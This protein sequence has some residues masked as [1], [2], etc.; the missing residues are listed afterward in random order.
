MSTQFLHIILTTHHTGNYHFVQR[1]PLVLKAVEKISADILQKD[2][3]PG[4]KKWLAVAQSVNIEIGIAANVDKPVLPLIHIG[5][6]IGRLNSPTLR[7]EQLNVVEIGKGVTK[8]RHAVYS[9]SNR[10]SIMLEEFDSL[11]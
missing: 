2:R 6:I 11:G 9:L 4:H 10:S 5:S 1:N 7:C 8:I 3:S